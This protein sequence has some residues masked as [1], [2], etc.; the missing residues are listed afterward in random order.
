MTGEHVH[1]GARDCDDGD[2]L[3]SCVVHRTHHVAPASDDV[4]S[5]GH[6]TGVAEVGGN[7]FP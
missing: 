4:S 2:G 3:R 1:D 5:H 6:L 7:A